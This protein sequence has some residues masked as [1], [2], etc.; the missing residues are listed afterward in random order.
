MRKMDGEWK[1]YKNLISLIFFYTEN[2]FTQNISSRRRRN[3]LTRGL[4]L[5]V[6][7]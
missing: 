1:R 2:M 7:K 5:V 3:T 6:V 4:F